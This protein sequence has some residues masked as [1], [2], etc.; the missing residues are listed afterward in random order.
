MLLLS[1]SLSMSLII[2]WLSA[3]PSRSAGFSWRVLDLREAVLS[4][5]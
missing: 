4:G 2:F 5:R 1:M 3:F